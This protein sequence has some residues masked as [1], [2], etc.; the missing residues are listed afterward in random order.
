MA[1]SLSQS[2]NRREVNVLGILPGSDPILRHEIIIIGT[3]YDHVGFDPDALVCPIG[4]DAQDT[5]SCVV[6]PG[7]SYSGNNDNASG[8]AVML[9]IARMWHELGYQ[10]KR[11][12]L[13]AAFGAQELGQVGSSYY[14]ENPIIPLEETVFMFQLDAVGGGS[15]HYLEAQGIWETEGLLLF[16]LQTAEDLVDGRLKITV[17]GHRSEMPPFF[18][19]IPQVVYTSPRSGVSDQIGF[20]EYGMPA[21]LVTWRGASEENW[22]DELAD[23]VDP[24]RITVAGKML[25]L[26]LMMLAR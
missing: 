3:H 7:L 24:Y 23:E 18:S 10:P 20:K 12:I 15:G 11:T 21:L 26:T 9:E 22:P 13:F 4:S 6:E 5:S 8:V 25:T 16:S 17:P 2:E 14:L 19:S 1:I